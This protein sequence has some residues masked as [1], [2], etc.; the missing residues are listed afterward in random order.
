MQVLWESFT[1]NV[2]H[3]SKEFDDNKDKLIKVQ[4]VGR[5]GKQVKAIALEDADDLVKNRMVAE[6][7]MCWR[8]FSIVRYGVCSSSGE[9]PWAEE[10]AKVWLDESG[11]PG[12]CNKSRVPRDMAGALSLGKK[13]G[14]PALIVCKQRW[15]R[16]GKPYENII[17]LSLH[18][19][20]FN[21]N[22]HHWW[23]MCSSV[24]GIRV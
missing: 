17:K 1:D 16:K 21:Y 8:A 14:Y 13:T 12:K 2:R 5:L 15:E 10:N 11:C 24:Q 18:R 3:S 4:A 7:Y 23:S 6:V 22:Q 9:A 20:A 19:F